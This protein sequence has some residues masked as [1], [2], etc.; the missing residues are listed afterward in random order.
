MRL[1]LTRAKRCRVTG[2]I[3]Y[4]Q[5]YILGSDLKMNLN[6]NDNLTKCPTCGAKDVIK[7][8]DRKCPHCRGS[9]YVPNK[10]SGNVGVFKCPK[11]NTDIKDKDVPCEKCGKTYS[12]YYFDHWQ[13]KDKLE[14][15]FYI[16]ILPNLLLMLLL[17]F[18][19]NAEFYATL[20]PK[21]VLGIAL[22]AII[23]LALLMSF[24]IIISNI[25][26][27][28]LRNILEGDILYLKHVI[29]PIIY[30]VIMLAIIFGTE[31]FAGL[32]SL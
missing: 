25:R 11:C 12:S 29:G 21:H 17:A 9:H 28:Y 20:L 32:L 4:S 7:S 8:N 5:Y 30:I 23:T 10:T 24:A 18:L 16:F 14:G 31:M 26:D 2:F 3:K 13:L 15:R 19:R 22:I 6:P 27:I 1:R